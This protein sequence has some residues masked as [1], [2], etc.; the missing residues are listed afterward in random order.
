[1][2]E[3]NLKNGL[4][5]LLPVIIWSIILFGSAPFIIEEHRYL[6]GLLFLVSAVVLYGYFVWKD[7]KNYF[8]FQALFS[9]I[10]LFTLGLASFQLTEY[11]VDWIAR[12]W[13][14]SGVGYLCLIC[15]LQLGRDLFP[16]LSKKFNMHDW[17][18]FKGEGRII[19]GLKE[20][21]LFALC[22]A[23]T[24]MSLLAFI[25]NI[26][27]KGYLPFFSDSPAAYTDFYTRF[28]IFIYA[29]T[30]ASGLCYY[31]L[32]KQKLSRIKK[33]LLWSAIIYLVFLMPTLIVSRGTFMVAALS[34]SAAVFFLNGRKLWV[35]VLCFVIMFAGYEVGSVARNLT[36]ESLNAL[37]QPKQ[38]EISN[39]NN[40]NQQQEIS[41][42]ENGEMNGLGEENNNTESQTGTAAPPIFQLPPK[43]LFFYT[44]LTVGHDNF[45]QAVRFSKSYAMGIRELVPFNVIL[46]SDSLTE[47]I[48]NAENY[49]VR[50]YLNT[51]NLFSDA[52][53]DFHLFGIV[54]LSLLWG[55]GFG[56]IEAF[57]LKYQTPCS[58]MVYGNTLTPVF[59]S[60]FTPWMSIFAVWLL[61][62]TT[63]LIFLGSSFSIR[64]KEI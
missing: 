7:H 10:W 6:V 18:V 34:L 45:D 52:Y 44:Y 9:G 55:V 16:A 15:G 60:F 56:I 4:K 61:W 19:F 39:D 54:F 3:M 5:K 14:Y 2:E 36:D 27:I 21:R 25:I 13:W 47:K 49:L 58:F 32:K 20:N 31:C 38:I 23:A 33:I 40:G 22:M 64:R 62:G 24:V 59:L 46:R 43:V 12:S 8:S 35:L 17:T 37:L 57:F 48:E 50:P 51:G 53:Y 28:N 63:F 1:M 11:Q 29:G 41:Q 26:Y 42:P 30:I